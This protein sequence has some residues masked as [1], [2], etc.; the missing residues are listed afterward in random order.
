MDTNKKRKT[1]KIHKLVAQAFLGDMPYDC[2]Q[3]NHKDGDKTNCKVSNLEYMT[4]SD[5][6]LHS[7]RVL[8]RK[9]VFNYGEKA[10]LSKLTNED[11]VKIRYLA[12][13]G[14]THKKISEQ[15]DKK[16]S[17]SEITKIINYKA[18]VHVKCQ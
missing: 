17:R 5:N 1:H 10:G 4:K 8:G 2:T 6:I 3:V 16:V 13:Q 18:W 15:I 12:N 9:T 7:F 11:V 14:L